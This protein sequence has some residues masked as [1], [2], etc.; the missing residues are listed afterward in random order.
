MRKRRSKTKRG[1]GVERK[2]EDEEKKRRVAK[3]KK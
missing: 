3:R 1:R 2:E